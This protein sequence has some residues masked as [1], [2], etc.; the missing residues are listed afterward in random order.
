MQGTRIWAL[1]VAVAAVL[2]VPVGRSEARPQQV[3]VGPDS[4]T[5]AEVRVEVEE[6]VRW[7]I[8]E[9]QHT[10]TSDDGLFDSGRAGPGSIFVA[11]F[12]NAGRFAYYCA[13]HGGPGGQGMSGVVVVGDTRRAGE[14]SATTAPSTTTSAP[15]LTS[16]TTPPATSPPPPLPPA[17]P[18][19]AASPAPT[20]A[21][22]PPRPVPAPAGTATSATTAT[23]VTPPET[24]TSTAPPPAPEPSPAAAVPSTAGPAPGHSESRDLYRIDR[25]A[26]QRRLT[27]ATGD[28]GDG[29]GGDAP[30]VVGGTL[31]ALAGMALVLPGWRARRR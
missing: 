1:L 4:F 22:T 8:R 2:V 3:E 31:L 27:A 18:L 5:P 12:H 19:A 6:T 7:V 23:T 30:V 29:G 13:V 17:A 20:P 15:R 26:R 14:Q 11:R 9:D 28:S 21:T 16:T 25:N 24:A 10:I